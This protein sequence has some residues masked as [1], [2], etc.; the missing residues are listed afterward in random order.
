MAEKQPWQST[1]PLL[2]AVSVRSTGP[3]STS[4]PRRKSPVWRGGLS[5]EPTGSSP[6]TLPYLPHSYVGIGC[7]E[8]QLLGTDRDIRSGVSF[9]GQSV[10]QFHRVKT[11]RLGKCRTLRTS[12]WSRETKGQHSSPPGA[13]LSDM[14][15]RKEYLNPRRS[16]VRMQSLWL[17]CSKR[18]WRSLSAA[19]GFAREFDKIRFLR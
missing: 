2:L 10:L 14:A 8:T 11:A 7:F 12:P 16:G 4:C 5:W 3:I 15:R 13:P 1:Y 9:Q 18:R 19:L 6:G 17:R